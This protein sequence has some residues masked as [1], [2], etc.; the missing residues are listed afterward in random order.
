MIGDLA[1]QEMLADQIV[2]LR[3]VLVQQI[4]FF[5]TKKPFQILSN[6]ILGGPGSVV[7]VPPYGENPSSI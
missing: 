7:A 2:L 4:V 6:N 5:H 3:I 1:A